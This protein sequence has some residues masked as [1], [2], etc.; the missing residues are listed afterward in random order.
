MTTLTAYFGLF[1]AY[2]FLWHYLLTI[3]S[4]R[5]RFLFDEAT[6]LWIGFFLASTHV[7]ATGML[8]KV[9]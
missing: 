1:C 8:N 2:S 6:V 4:F 5:I 7:W 3:A 9:C